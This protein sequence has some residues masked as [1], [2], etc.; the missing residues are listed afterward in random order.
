MFLLKQKS[1]E[2]SRQQCK[3]F[4]KLLHMFLIFE[5]RQNI[6]WK[7]TVCQ[8]TVINIQSVI[9]IV[10]A[11]YCILSRVDNYLLLILYNS[12]TNWRGNHR[13]WYQSGNCF[14]VFERKRAFC[15]GGMI[16]RR[17]KNYYLCMHCF[18]IRDEVKIEIEEIKQKPTFIENLIDN[19]GTVGSL[20]ELVCKVEGHP[21]PTVTWYK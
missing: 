11:F 17:C 3:T 14:F 7:I 13:S 1:K 20:L 8:I 2:R 5:W 12:Y 18:T 16:N 4:K 21:M 10:F 15:N 19:D 9:P 6:G